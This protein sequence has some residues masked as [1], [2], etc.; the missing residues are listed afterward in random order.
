ME[1]KKYKRGKY[2]KTP[3]KRVR[4]TAQI[5]VSDR[6]IIKDKDGTIAKG[7]RFYAQYLKDLND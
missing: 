7:L 3:V 5:S 1:E 4:V 2:K 6:D